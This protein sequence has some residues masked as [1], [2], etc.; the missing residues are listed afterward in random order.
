MC[1]RYGIG[2]HLPI[3]SFFSNLDIDNTLRKTQEQFAKRERLFR[4]VEDMTSQATAAQNELDHLRVSLEEKV[5]GEEQMRLEVEK[6]R[7]EVN[8]LQVELQS[9][10]VQVKPTSSNTAHPVSK[11]SQ[12]DVEIEKRVFGIVPRKHQ[13]TFLILLVLVLELVL[14]AVIFA[15]YRTYISTLENALLFN[16]EP[17]EYFMDEILGAQ[18]SPA[19]IFSWL[20]SF[21]NL[22]E[23]VPTEDVPFPANFIPS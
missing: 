17:F 11:P 10:E 12:T 16:T 9:K 4:E 21:S 14:V 20:A 2:Y 8:R 23:D 6:M 19:S 13:W 15:K 3:Y 1:I 5:Q 18:R 22:F 7:H